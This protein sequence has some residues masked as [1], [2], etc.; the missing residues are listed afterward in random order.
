MVRSLSGSASSFAASASTSSADDHVVGDVQ[1]AP[2]AGAAPL[3][4]AAVAVE[5]DDEN[6]PGVEFA[7]VGGLGRARVPDARRDLGRRVAVAEGE[8]VDPPVGQRR[9]GLPPGDDGGVR[10]V[11]GEPLDDPVRHAEAMAAREGLQAL[12]GLRHEVAARVLGHPR[13]ADDLETG[14]HGHGSVRLQDVDVP[15]PPVAELRGAVDAGGVECVVVPGEH[16]DGAGDLLERIE[17]AA[18]RQPV[19]LVR[20]EPVAGHEDQFAA[21]LGGDAGQCADRVD[22]RLHVPRER[23]VAQEVTA[24]AEL[25]VGG[26]QEADFAHGSLISGDSCGVACAGGYTEIAFSAGGSG[27]G[28]YVASRQALLSQSYSWCG[29]NAAL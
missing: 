21:L 2:G 1:E 16:V 4:A 24:H 28:A 29:R 20:L 23:L 7:E 10:L 26:V 15:R 12:Q 11:G 22:A 18:D 27:S 13:H 25:P 6:V 17:G 14:T 9:L 8:E 3:D 19:D 5:F